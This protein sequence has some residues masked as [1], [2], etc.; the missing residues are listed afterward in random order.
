MSEQ[1]VQAVAAELAAMEADE[2][3]DTLAAMEISDIDKERIA[4]LM[5]GGVEFVTG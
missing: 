2:A 4:E 1:E 3:A 5:Q